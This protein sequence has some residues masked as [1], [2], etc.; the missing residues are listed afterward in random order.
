MVILEAGVFSDQYRRPYE[1]VVDARSFNAIQGRINDYGVGGNKNLEPG[2]LAGVIDKVLQR[3]AAP[4]TDNEGRPLISNIKN[5]WG[6]SRYRFYMFVE[7]NNGINT[8]TEIYQGW[9]ENIDHSL[10]QGRINPQLE[11]TINSSTV[12]DSQTVS[13]PTGNESSFRLLGAN[14]I[15]SDDGYSGFSSRGFQKNTELYTMRPTE[16]IG[17][18]ATT[19]WRDDITVDATG[20][21][22]ASPVLSKRANNV[23]ASYAS[24]ILKGMHTAHAVD[25]RNSDLY[26]DVL[27][28]AFNGLDSYCS[29]AKQYVQETTP[30][31]LEF[32]NALIQVRGAEY[33]STFTLDDL[34]QVD[35]DVDK[36]IAAARIGDEYRSEMPSLNNSEHW[37]GTDD[38]THAAVMLS[39]VI[40][41]L[42]I[43]FGLV[44]I[45]FIATNLTLIG[46]E[47]EIYS[48]KPPRGYGRSDMVEEFEG[49]KNAF[50][51]RCLPVLTIGGTREFEF[52]ITCDTTGDSLY[53]IKFDGDRYFTP[54]AFPTFCDS[55]IAPI[56]TSDVTGFNRLASDLHHLVGEVV[57]DSV[58]NVPAT[59]RLYG[60]N[61]DGGHGGRTNFGFGNN[62]G[63]RSEPGF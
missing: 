33:A 31:E 51:T 13:R 32:I 47:V 7:V 52:R 43:E 54:F 20:L 19:N 25:R 37:R 18:M 15:L 34:R 42:M 28:E 17:R 49:F 59:R 56:R 35:P 46:S 38:R 29:Q 58:D 11:F 36:N 61:E 16:I 10:I 63:R 12:V 41:S 2:I 48:F 3:R 8:K 9:S 24:R 6:E 60:D 39:G 23:P 26:D 1:S 50:A 62:S 55:L 22:G 27:P 30:T 45:G 4:E 14:Q 5:G 40:P 53:E 21:L 44:S 57:L